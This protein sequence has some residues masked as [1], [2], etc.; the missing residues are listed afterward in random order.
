MCE[1]VSW[2]VRY[3]NTV[4]KVKNAQNVFL[5]APLRGEGRA[6]TQGWGALLAIF[7]S[8]LVPHGPADRR[9]VGIRSVSGFGRTDT[10]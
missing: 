2:C 7:S 4:Q 6:S 10:F 9:E 5:S 1:C 3:R 8:P